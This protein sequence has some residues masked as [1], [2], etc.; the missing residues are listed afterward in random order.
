MSVSMLE[1]SRPDIASGGIDGG[2]RSASR[3][4]SSTAVRIRGTATTRMG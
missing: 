1:R 3:R 2:V 4:K